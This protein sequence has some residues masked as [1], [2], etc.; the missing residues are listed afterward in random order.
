MIHFLLKNDCRASQQNMI[1]KELRFHKWHMVANISYRN[2]TCYVSTTE[3]DCA[4]SF[5][6]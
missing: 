6:E 2:I 1:I 3:L 4:G 5:I